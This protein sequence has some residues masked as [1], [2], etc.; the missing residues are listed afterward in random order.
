MSARED[1]LFWAAEPRTA[2]LHALVAP[3]GESAV[4]VAKL[5]GL[6]VCEAPLAPALY[7]VYFQDRKT[8][9]LDCALSAAARSFTLWHELGHYLHA[10]RYAPQVS[11]RA[12]EGFCDGFACRATGTDPAAADLLFATDA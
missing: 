11:A 3:A 2:A 12:A 10:H 9:V 7:G 5:C 1:T 4:E 6:R 8:I